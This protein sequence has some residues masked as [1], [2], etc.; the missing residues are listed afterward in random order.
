MYFPCSSEVCSTVG[1]PTFRYYYSE[2][3]YTMIYIVVFLPI[4]P[5]QREINIV[6]LGVFG[7][8]EEK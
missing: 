5:K 4:F 6:N 7:K 2:N 1:I 8:R 3:I